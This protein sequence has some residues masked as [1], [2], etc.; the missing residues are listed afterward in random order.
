MTFLTKIGFSS[1]NCRWLLIITV[2]LLGLLMVTG[3]QVQASD[4]DFSHLRNDEEEM[5]DFKFLHPTQG[6]LGY[7]AV[8]E[9][10]E[11][12]KSMT[13]EKREKYLKKHPVPIVVGPDGK[14]LFLIDHHH[15]SLAT[16]RMG[17][18]KIRIVVIKNKSDL[19]ME[20]FV[21]WLKSQKYVY[22]FDENDRLIEFKDL[23]DS[24]LK[25]KDDPYRSLAGVVE[26]H[27]GF[28]KIK[29][30]FMEFTWARFFRKYFSADQINNSF[31][32]TLAA[33]V[34]LAQ[35]YRASHLPGFKGPPTRCVERLNGY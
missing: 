9:K 10:E 25:M 11:K 2:L 30:P 14:S 1:P 4:G 7:L 3:V 16:A 21:A 27:G 13:D 35:S 22:L 32:R 15:L 31:E 29:V 33:A 6:G 24:I 28:D 20:E 17:I 23:P 8:L 12:L 34:S 5:V 19:T 26:D 18:E